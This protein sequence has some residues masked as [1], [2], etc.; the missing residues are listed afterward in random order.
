MRKI[1]R[2]CDA[3][4]LA[5]A[6]S[7]VRAASIPDLLLRRD[8][9]L[10]N[11]TECS[12]AG[13]PSYFCCPQGQI[14]N[15]LAANTTILCCPSGADCTSIQPISCDISQ[16]D[17][18]KNPSAVIKTTLLNGVMFHCGSGT[19]CPF[20][21]SCN[22]NG[23]CSKDANQAVLPFTTSAPPAASTSPGT[24]VASSGAQ[25]SAISSSNS[26]THSSAV[27]PESASTTGGS[28]VNATAQQ[29]STGSSNTAAI[30]GGSVAA[31]IGTIFVAAIAYI[32]IR[33]RNARK[34]DDGSQKSIRSTSSFGNLISNPIM[35]ENT[36]MRSDFA[37]RSP[38]RRTSTASSAAARAN[39][40]R[41]PLG[42]PPGAGTGVGVAIGTAG[43]APSTPPPR[44]VSHQS[45]K[46]PPIRNMRQSSIAYG[47]G[48]PNTSQYH[49]ET[50]GSPGSRPM[51]GTRN[52]RT[53][54]PREP[55]SMSIDVFADAQTVGRSGGAGNPDRAS[56]L[57]RFSR[58]TTMTT[59]TE[60]ARRAGM[61]DVAAGK[62][63]FVPQSAYSPASR[64]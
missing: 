13:L 55:S 4:F 50:N 25:T 11:F 39:E 58:D 59:F 24:P 49:G 23:Q 32:C 18:Q 15:V 30:V 10:P 54:E 6:S 29:S 5:L 9:C 34:I 12:Q 57:R 47:V 19:C 56:A 38:G 17:G 7:Y 45:A 20:G 16:Q 41:G 27:I 1:P 53:P 44:V 3:V 64:R 51:V 31:V 62:E 48:A 14:C 63:P 43:S 21:Y 61:D 52:L 42:T 28:A 36:T 26:P 8:T 2:P 22:T 33:K 37:R 46:V 40:P 60:M 35:T